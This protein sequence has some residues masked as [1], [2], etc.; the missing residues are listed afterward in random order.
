MANTDINLAPGEQGVYAKGFSPNLILFW[1]K[2]QIAVT[3]RRIAV[4]QPNTI[5]GII[6]LGYEESSMP[7]GSI[8]GIDASL[9]VRPARLLIFAVLALALLFSGFDM[10]DDSAGGGFFLVLLG[11]MAAAAAAN[12]ITCALGLTNNGG[13]KNYI[14]VSF[15][16]QSKLEEFKNRAN[17]Y[18]YSATTP[19]VS[20]DQ[21][22]AGQGVPNGAQP[23]GGWTPQ[24]QQPQQGGWTPQPQQPQQGGW[25]QQSQ[26]GSWGQQHSQPQQP[27][28][29]QQ[30]S[31]PQHQPQQREESQF[32]WNGHQE[33]KGGAETPSEKSNDDNQE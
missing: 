5:A 21:Y 3:N 2:T 22:G 17:E 31:Q 19:G 14:G 18:V 32:G 12:A 23:Q 29:S 20:W 10:M 15:L 4:K 27:F 11:L 6:P 24:P 26:Q 13:G 8:A 7:I 33:P 28:Q 16:E 25:H 1:L 30:Y 9:K